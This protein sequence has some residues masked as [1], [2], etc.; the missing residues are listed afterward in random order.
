MKCPQRL[1]LL[2]GTR[3]IVRIGVMRSLLQE[4]RRFS[5]TGPSGRV[6]VNV[7]HPATSTA[8][9]SV[10]VSEGGLCLRLQD[11]LEVRSLVRLQLT[12]GDS[13]VRKERSVECTGR[14]AWIVQRLD[15]RD[16]PPFLFDV[17][18]EFIQPSRM[19]RQLLTQGG[20]RLALGKPHP[21]RMRTMEPVTARGRCFIPRLQ[22]E[23]NH[24]LHW[25]LVVS[26]DGTPCFSGHYPS[27]RVAL[28]AWAHFRRQQL[29]LAKQ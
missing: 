2:R 18:I 12:Q 23:A 19:V 1:P 13:H 27:E 17:G 11:M 15:L 5:R 20:Q 7:L 28:A 9:S 26:V 4:R 24:A 16:S 22:R 8:P 10:N 6:A 21:V 3:K 14:V 25:H 29:K